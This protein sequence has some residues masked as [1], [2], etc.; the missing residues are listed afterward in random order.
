[1]ITIRSLTTFLSVASREQILVLRNKSTVLSRV[2]K[3]R[4]SNYLNY[5]NYHLNELNKIKSIS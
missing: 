2:R 5:L 3:P 1:M 4:V